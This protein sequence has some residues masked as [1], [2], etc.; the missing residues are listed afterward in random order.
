MFYYLPQKSLTH[1]CKWEIMRP[2]AQMSSLDRVNPSPEPLA[3][4]AEQ[5]SLRTAGREFKSWVSRRSSSL[6]LWVMMLYFTCIQLCCTC[7]RYS[8]AQNVSHTF[9]SWC[10]PLLSWVRS[11]RCAA[12]KCRPDS[13]D[14]HG[15][16]TANIDG[17]LAC[18]KLTCSSKQ[19]GIYILRYF[20]F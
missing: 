1:L 16:H 20:I 11:C 13:E 18:W 7:I 2:T 10:R 3:A 5:D 14:V 9:G 4:A 8:I 19:T 12:V 17:Q 15:R 6:S